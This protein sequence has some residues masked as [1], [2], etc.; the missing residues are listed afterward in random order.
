MS[1]LVGTLMICVIDE[2]VLY[3]S[4]SGLRIVPVTLKESADFT[5]STPVF[6]IFRKLQKVPSIS[7][8]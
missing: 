7:H 5:L 8:C 4:N 6:L 3:L 1:C 2:I